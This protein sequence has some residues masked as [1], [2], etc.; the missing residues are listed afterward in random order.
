MFNFH[1]NAVVPRALAT[2]SSEEMFYS[3]HKFVSKVVGSKYS[4]EMFYS[5]DRVVSR[6]MATKTDV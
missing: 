1:P 2:K 5:Y 4:E 3:Y 6:V